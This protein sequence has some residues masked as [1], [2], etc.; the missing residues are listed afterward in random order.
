V[1]LVDDSRDAAESMQALLEAEGHA[2]SLA[3]TGQ[4]ALEEA[5]RAQPDVVILDLDLPDIH[6]CE[7]A[8]RLRSQT[9]SATA[10]L[11]ALTGSDGEQDRQAVLAAGFNQYFVKPANPAT[12]LQALSA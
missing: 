8:R 12:L 3:F 5:Q 2:V 4:S 1:L 9:P 10:L 7:V 11:F 6:G